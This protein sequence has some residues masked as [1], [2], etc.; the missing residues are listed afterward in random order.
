MARFVFTTGA[1]TVS[2]GVSNASISGSTPLAPA[3]A[4]SSVVSSLVLAMSKGTDG[5]DVPVNTANSLSSNC[6]NVFGASAT[7]LETVAG[8]GLPAALERRAEISPISLI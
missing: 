4:R 3:A 1:T 8:A 6:K 7:V 2:V 5:R